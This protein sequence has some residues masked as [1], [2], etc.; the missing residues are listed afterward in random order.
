[1]VEEV[2]NYSQLAYKMWD[3]LLS[4]RLIVTDPQKNGCVNSEC[5]CT[6]GGCSRAQMCPLPLLQ[7]LTDYA[8]H[9]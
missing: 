4:E 8:Y 9:R 3:L 5:D 1:M 6:L 2:L 7:T